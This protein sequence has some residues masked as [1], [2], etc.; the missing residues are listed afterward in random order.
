MA[1]SYT[2]TITSIRHMIGDSSVPN[3]LNDTIIQDAIDRQ[4]VVVFQNEIVP[5]HSNMKVYRASAGNWLE[6]TIYDANDTEVTAS[7]SDLTRGYWK[8][9]TAQDR[10]Y[11]EGTSCNIY[12]A[13]AECITILIAVLRKEYSFSTA[14]GSFNRNERIDTLKEMRKAY[15]QASLGY[16]LTNDFS[17]ENG[18]QREIY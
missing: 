13:A 2:A 15:Q 11:I 9:S 12:A 7:S 3:D 10:L 17:Y 18:T 1:L 8:F 14:E 5:A 16:S 4:S 6:A